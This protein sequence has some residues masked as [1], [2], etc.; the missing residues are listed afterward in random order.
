MLLLYNNMI[1][2]LEGLDIILHK[3]T[4]LQIKY[5]LQNE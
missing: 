1:F 5:Y 2:I 3:N 4:I